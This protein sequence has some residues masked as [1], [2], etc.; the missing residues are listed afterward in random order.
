MSKV[1]YIHCE[2][3]GKWEV[4]QVEAHR[5]YGLWIVTT[6]PST[7]PEEE[8]EFRITHGPTGW[9]A[10][11]HFYSIEEAE[12]AMVWWARGIVRIGQEDVFQTF[13]PKVIQAAI[14]GS[15]LKKLYREAMDYSPWNERQSAQHD[16]SPAQVNDEPPCTCAILGMGHA[17]ECAWKQW[18][19]S[20]D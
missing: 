7:D 9:A 3:A 12:R 13:D 2:K 1:A 18:K 10:L 15:G 20:Y 14:P 16:E 8:D 19:Q 5:Q 17:P 4:I 11:P 6:V